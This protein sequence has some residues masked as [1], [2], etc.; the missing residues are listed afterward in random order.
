MEFYLVDIFCHLVHLFSSGHF[1]SRVLFCHCV[2]LYGHLLLMF[3][4]L[5][6]SFVTDVLQENKVVSIEIIK[7][8]MY[9]ETEEDT[10]F[11]FTSTVEK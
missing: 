11:K 4:V 8:K 1:D 6:F 3:R 7:Y 10:V 2:R 9:S 5:S